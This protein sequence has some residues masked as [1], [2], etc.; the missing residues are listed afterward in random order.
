MSKIHLN[1]FKW[2]FTH[3][4]AQNVWYEENLLLEPRQITLAF[5]PIN[6]HV[7]CIDRCPNTPPP[8]GLNI[9]PASTDARFHCF[10]PVNQHFFAVG[11]RH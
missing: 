8:G 2:H 11:D 5:Y 10:F 4:K 3:N 9:S 1:Y 7:K 6:E